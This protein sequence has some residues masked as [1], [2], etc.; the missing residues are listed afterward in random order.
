MAKKIVFEWETIH[1]VGGSCTRR[2]KVMG[3]WLVMHLTM[4]TKTHWTESMIFIAD[5]DWQWYIL[6]PP[7]ESNEV[8]KSNLANEFK[9]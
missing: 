8:A 3:G 7:L 9:A 1:E 2:A 6:K 5:N 4:G